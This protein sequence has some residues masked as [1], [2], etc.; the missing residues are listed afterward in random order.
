MYFGFGVLHIVIILFL[1]K[2]CSAF[3]RYRENIDFYW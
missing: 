2:N 1:I 3:C